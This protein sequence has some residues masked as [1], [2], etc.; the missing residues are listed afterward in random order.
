MTVTGVPLWPGCAV[1]PPNLATGVA[2]SRTA[3]AA[4]F[5]LLLSTS[6]GVRAPAQPAAD[7]AVVR[8]GMT[9][10]EVRQILGPPARVARQILFRRHLEQWIYD[11]PEAARVEFNCVRG[12]EPYV[13]TVAHPAV[14]AP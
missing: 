13:L 8:R 11:Q 2:Q 10:A 9:P 1:M 14:P 6:I 12:E 4:F 7:R 3:L 5:L